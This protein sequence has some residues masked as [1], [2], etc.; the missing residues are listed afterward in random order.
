MARTNH[1][2]ALTYS[3]QDYL[4]G[5]YELTANG[6]P[7]TTNAIAERRGITPASVTGM[8]QKLAGLKP[9]LVSYKKHRGVHLTDSGRRAA[10][11][12]IRHHRLLETWLA[13]T[14]GYSWDEVHGEAER[15]E[16]AM[17]E[18]MEERIAR[19]LGDPARDP[20]GEPIPS[21]ELIMPPDLSVPLA[22]LEVGQ[23]A[24]VRRVQPQE[25]L[26]LRR[27]QGIGLHIGSLVEVVGLSSYDQLMTL[28]VQGQTKDTTLGPALT[29]RV[30]VEPTRHITE[31][32]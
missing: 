4:K 31:G 28:H 19:A 7:A 6:E 21:A 18:E 2:P 25:S 24:I 26:A 9:A 16:H 22:D 8:M 15:L 27:L 17:S 12:V 30:Y 23:S 29:R 32:Q 20:H 13:E 1:A 14:L 10:L 11:E 3:V 5:I